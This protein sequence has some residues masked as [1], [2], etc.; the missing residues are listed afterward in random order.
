MRP[1]VPL[2]T[3]ALAASLLTGCRGREPAAVAPPPAP[4]PATTPAA[5]RVGVV[6]LQAVVSAHPRW[7]EL[8]DIRA[9]V[10]RVEGELA[11]LPPPPPAPQTDIKR[12]LDQEAA[13]MRA[14]FTRDLD[15]MKEEQRRALEAYA[16]ELRKDQ[17]AK[18]EAIRRQVEAEAEAAIVAK[19]D[20]LKAQLRSAEQAI[21]EEY[22]YPLLNLRLRAE[23][24]G[25]RSEEEG[26]AVLR[27]LQALQQER[28]ERVRAKAE[29]IEQAFQEFQKA[30]EADVNARLKAE[31]DAVNAESQKLI[32]SREQQ[33]Q[34]EL[35]RVVAERERVFQQRLEQRRKELVAAA[36]AQLRGGQAAYA[37]EVE[38]RAQRLRAELLTLQQQQLRLEDSILAEVRIEAA[39]VAQAQGLDVVLTRTLARSGVVDITADVVRKLR[40]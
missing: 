22:R 7:K 24:A 21:M 28:E 27:Q 38:V 2:L 33:I 35:R 20:E 9:R 34:S 39:T 18:L 30:T 13:T 10:A 17:A 29:E 19:R 25:L 5:P 3:L 4:G 1:A 37:R 26:Q 36:E 31:Q 15:A 32:A 11:V 12:I 23:V 16:E 8:A 6:D 40:P 14:S